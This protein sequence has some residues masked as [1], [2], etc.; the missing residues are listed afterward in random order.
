MPKARAAAMKALE[1]D[2]TLAEVHTTLA[3]VLMTYD[4]N[5]SGAKKE[6]NLG[7]QRL[8]SGMLDRGGESAA[9]SSNS[10]CSLCKWFFLLNGAIQQKP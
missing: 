9:A 7:V 5:W 2:D 3:R 8:R 6:L 4:W 1:L 10:L